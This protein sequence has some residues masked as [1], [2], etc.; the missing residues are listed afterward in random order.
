MGTRVSTLSKT[1]RMTTGLALCGLVLAGCGSSHKPS[2]TTTHPSTSTSMAAHGTRLAL[3]T[4]NPAVGDCTTNTSEK[5]TSVG[6]V[7]LTV[8][9]SSV[10]ADIHLQ[11]GTPNTTYGVFMQ[12]VPGSC[13]QEQSN[14][15]SLTTNSK[16][17]A[18]YVATVPRVAGATTFFVQLVNGAT[19][20]YTSDRLSKVS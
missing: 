4:N 18:T 20:T 16:G 15:G 3:G 5:S 13:P 12:Q 8:T 6:Y 14:G 19:A 7:T 2:T 17:R 11:S 1:L 9:S 10:V